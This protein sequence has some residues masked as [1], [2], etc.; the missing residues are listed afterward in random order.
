VM[1]RVCKLTTYNL[2]V[3][4]FNSFSFYSAVFYY[5]SLRLQIY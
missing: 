4:S 3:V 1:L 5:Q 2:S